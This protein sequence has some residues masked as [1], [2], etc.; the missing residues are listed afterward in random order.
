MSVRL[1]DV[2]VLISLLDSAHIHHDIAVQWFRAVAAEGWA[3]CPITENG[4]IRVVSHPSYPNLRLMPVT[5]AESLARFKAGFSDVHRFWAD[6][7]S[8]NETEL[9]DLGVLIGSR[10]TTDTYLAGLAFRNGGRLA[11]LDYGIPW[12]AVRG[13]GVG[14][15]ERIVA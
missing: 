1:L 14:L 5:A 12:R 9:F 3:S 10:Q 7:I 15:V 4:F 11:T 6:D 2:N 8:L 13:A